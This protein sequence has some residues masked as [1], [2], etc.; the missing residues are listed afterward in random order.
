M[1]HAINACTVN[2]LKLKLVYAF[3]GGEF[4]LKESG[5]T[6]GM[7]SESNWLKVLV[8]FKINPLEIYTIVLQQRQLHKGEHMSV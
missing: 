6:F 5:K 4:G 2:N 8:L 1:C 3:G 7:L